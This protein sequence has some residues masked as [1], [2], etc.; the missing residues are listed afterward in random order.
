MGEQSS[1]EWLHDPFLGRQG[2]SLNPWW[3]CERVS[4]A[5]ANCFIFRQP[6]LRMRGLVFDKA[7]I[8]GK[9]EIIYADRKVLLGPLR[10]RQPLMIFVESLGDLWHGKVHIS[11]TADVYALA[12]LAPH[13]IFITTTKRVPRQRNWLTF[14][15]FPRHVADAVERLAAEHTA[16]GGRF[17]GGELEAARAHLA[18]S[19]AAGTAMRPAPNVWVGCT[20]ENNARAAERIPALRATPAAVRW[21]SCEPPTN[22]LTD[23]LDLEPYFE[24]NAAA[25]DLG[26]PAIDWVVFGGE[27]GPAAKATHLDTEPAVGLRPIDLG[28][29]HRQIQ[30]V[31][32]EGA[33]AF[34]KQLGEPWSAEHGAAQRQGRDITEWPA[35]L[36]VRR[37]PRQLAA[38][39]LDVDPG[40]VPALQDL[41]GPGPAAA[42]PVNAGHNFLEVLR[43]G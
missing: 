7:G 29:L 40:N 33:R 34:V 12:L 24:G 11:R 5:C 6:P 30:V 21:L 20:V 37:Y 1:I 25:L 4:E 43:D 27:S 31:T 42:V 38:R 15:R 2:A 16:A 26:W 8:G 3:G 9:T 39:A 32:A 41:T 28:N 13:H 19:L 35:G 36:Q 22:E 10:R 23:P 18:P 17:R 14:P